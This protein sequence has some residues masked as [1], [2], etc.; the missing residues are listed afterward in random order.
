V[1]VVLLGA[2]V[3]TDDDTQPA[4]PVDVTLTPIAHDIGV[5]KSEI[6]AAA[7]ALPDS[8]VCSLVCDPD[9]FRAR[10]TDE[11]MRGGVCYQ[12]RCELA[13]EMAVTVGVCLP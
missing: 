1:I 4:G 11:G 6:C 8:D 12:F 7:A 10:L 5:P 3:A 2:C 9:A 13:P